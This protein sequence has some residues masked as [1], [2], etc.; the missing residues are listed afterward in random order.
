MS[1]EPESPA[2]AAPPAWPILG[3]YERRALGVLVEKAKTT[4]DAYPM[5]VNALVTAEQSRLN[6]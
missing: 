1:S 2:P 4:P 5:S 3:L 6:K